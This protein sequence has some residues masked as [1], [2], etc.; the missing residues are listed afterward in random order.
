[1][2]AYELITS[3]LLFLRESVQKKKKNKKKTTAC[4]QFCFSM[5]HEQVLKG[6]LNNMCMLPFSLLVFFLRIFSFMVLL[7][8]SLE[9]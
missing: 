6:F 4:G 5:R 1:M 9:D 8:N 3:S 7:R 2:I